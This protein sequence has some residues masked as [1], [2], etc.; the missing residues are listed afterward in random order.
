MSST[1]HSAPRWQL[2]NR[3]ASS[4][5]VKR[6]QKVHILRQSAIFVKIQNSISASVR[7]ASDWKKCIF[8]RKYQPNC[9]KN[10]S[11]L[12][13]KPVC[14]EG[15]WSF[16]RGSEFVARIW[17]F[18]F[19]KSCVAKERTKKKKN[20]RKNNNNSKKADFLSCVFWECETTL[21]HVGRSALRRTILQDEQR[22]GRKWR[23]RLWR[24]QQWRVGDSAEDGRRRPPPSS[25]PRRRPGHFCRPA[26]V[27][28]LVQD[29]PG[30][31]EG[32]IYRLWTAFNS[33]EWRQ[34]VED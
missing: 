14:A 17:R 10:R 29:V 21:D 28:V 15:K 32:S 5:T 18:K 6:A 9:G 1:S 3:F 4:R 12:Q 24:I 25:P 19:A 22:S 2:S 23:R 7:S 16:V 31:R 34:S 20:A 11:V 27:R 30:R 26:G 33:M 8:R 13:R